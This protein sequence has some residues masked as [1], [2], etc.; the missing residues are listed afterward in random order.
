MDPK[1]MQRRSSEKV[2]QVI[3]LMRSL[4]LSVE[5]RQKLSPQGFLENTVFW[6]DSEKYPASDEVIP[7]TNDGIIEVQEEKEIPPMQDANEDH[8][9][10]TN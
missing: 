7:T 1:E 8:V 10:Q 3:D 5:A 6:L 9:A 4:H 2:K